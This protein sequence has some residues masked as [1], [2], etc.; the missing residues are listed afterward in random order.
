MSSLHSLK[1]KTAETMR[2]RGHLPLAW[3]NLGAD[4][5]KSTRALISCARCGRQAAVDT[6]PPANGIDIGGPAV[7][8]SCEEAY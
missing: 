4:K 2:A 6:Q 5:R 8:V 7:A 1:V 3:I